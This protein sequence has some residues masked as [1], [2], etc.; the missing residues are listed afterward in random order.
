MKKQ[1]VIKIIGG[2]IIFTFA[3][4]FLQ[5]FSPL[6]ADAATTGLNWTNPNKTG[7][8]YKF[9]PL[10]AVNSQ[11]IMQVV[12]CSGVVDKVTNAITNLYANSDLKTNI[13]EF[14][15]A[16]VVTACNASKGAAQWVVGMIGKDLAASVGTMIDCKAVT[17]TKDPAQ[18]KA[19]I[20]V[21]KKAEAA[22]K[23]TECY[24]GIAMTLAK[25]Q[26][27]DMTRYT[28]N[29]IN[30]GFNGNPMYVQNI[31]SLTNNVEK[32]V[33]ENGL[34]ALTG[35]S[36]KAFP[37]G[38]DFARSMVNSYQAG[39]SLK[40]GATNFLD[41]LTSDLGAFI[42]DPTSLLPNTTLN[43][44]QRAQK[45]NDTFAG[46]FSSGGWNAWLAL[47]QKDANNPLGFAMQVSQYEADQQ[48]AQ[49]QGTKDELAQ[50]NGFLSQ[51]KCVKYSNP[52]GSDPA[53]VGNMPIT[54]IAPIGTGTL[55]TTST[56]SLGLQGPAGQVGTSNNSISTM[57]TIGYTSP[58]TTSLGLQGPAGQ[59]QVGTPVCL[60]WDVVTPGSI[61][62]DQLSAFVTSPVRQLELAKTI[63][64]S[65]NSVFSS[66]LSSLQN[67]GLPGLSSNQNSY[68]SDNLTAGANIATTDL[69]GNRVSLSSG[70][71]DGSFDL[72][73]DLG[74]I[75][76]H[77]YP[78]K[79][80]GVWNADKNLPELN[81][82][83][84]PLDDQGNP[85]LN[86]YFTVSVA[87]N[88]KIIAEGYNGWAKGDRAFWDGKQWQN[89][90]K[91][92]ADPIANRGVIQIQK[93]YIVAAKELLANLPVIMPKIGELDYCIPGPN[94]S[95]QAYSG[96]A[97]GAFSDYAYSLSSDLK[98][99][100]SFIARDTTTYKIAQPGTDIYDNYKKLFEGTNTFSGELETANAREIPGTGSYATNDVIKSIVGAVVAGPIGAII[101][102]VGIF[103]GRNSVNIG[104]QSSP[105]AVITTQPW[106][107][108]NDLST[109][110]G[111]K[112]KTSVGKIGDR[113]ATELNDISKNLQDFT[114]QY[115]QL[116]NDNY[117][118]DGLMQKQFI[119]KEDTSEQLPNSAWLPMASDGLNITKD[120]VSYSTDIAQTAQNYKDDIIQENTN[121]SK[122]NVIK[123]QVSVIIKAAQKRRD[124][125]LLKILAAEA[126]R[127]GTPVLTAAQYKAKYAACLDEENIVFYEDTAIMN[128]LGGEA[129][130]CSDGIDND[131]NGLVDAKDPACQA[132]SVANT[133]IVEPLPVVKGL[134][135]DNHITTPDT[136]TNNSNTQQQQVDNL[137][138]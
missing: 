97:Y 132:Q 3:M 76:I 136:T 119:E 82:G 25:N 109:T 127:N 47:T 44:L 78:T 134:F 56:S 80:Q 104:T 42:T 49:M 73:R 124:D 79:P 108:L 9:N 138:N 118:V 103:G 131:L 95:W 45:A 111:I 40:S 4:F 96:D 30:S 72:T 35:P 59:T 54:P 83:V 43:A 135:G 28:M 106:I 69:L 84:A 67:Q 31:T 110:G 27:T 24:N 46:D 130:R 86:V 70:Y 20:D 77:N 19:I 63:N 121:I 66:L 14:E 113:V 7:N 8:T 81:I 18:L 33:L 21:A 62:K 137:V 26:L 71:T 116:M 22:R 13:D 93:D 91:G 122:L 10:S 65:L 17:Q 60:Q 50:N 89:W 112:N 99:G 126:T 101:G 115:T 92:V 39:T 117:G 75:Y 15:A 6:H 51:K 29:W 61:I 1:V 36:N 105:S 34:N 57:G 52:D 123:D 128:N 87:G 5:T 133:G 107:D 23:T 16:A 2:A 55:N 100:S 68:S 125:N 90:K 94:P 48:A 74:N 53:I 37:Y 98:M 85:L 12:G 58:T 88:T 11:L 129:G 38:A 102:G 120:I 32:G 41:S 114:T 64:D